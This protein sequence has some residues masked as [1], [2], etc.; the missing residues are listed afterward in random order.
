MDPLENIQRGKNI[1]ISGTTNL[2]AGTG[3]TVS[4]SMLAHSCTPSNIPDKLGERSFCGGSCRPG[5]GSSYTVRVIEGTGG[6]N[7]WN[8][9]INTTGW[10]TEMYSI[11]AFAG[12]GTNATHAT[13]LIRYGPDQ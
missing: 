8:A 7:S 13:Q 2:T 4:Y 3:I 6:V 11:G 12:K 9:T 10:C 1:F 5:E